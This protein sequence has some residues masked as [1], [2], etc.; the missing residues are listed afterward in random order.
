MSAQLSA[1][2]TAQTVAQLLPKLHDVDPDHRFMSLNDL[3]QVL[4]ISKQDLL[5]G[6]YVIAARAVDGIIKTLDDQNGEA[7]YKKSGSSSQQDTI[8]DTCPIT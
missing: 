7:N 5:T 1:I 2:S 4:T 6:D 8:W 3:F